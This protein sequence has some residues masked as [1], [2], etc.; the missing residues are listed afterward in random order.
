MAPAASGQRR[1]TLVDRCSGV[2]HQDHPDGSSQFP[3]AYQPEDH[4]RCVYASTAH[5]PSSYDGRGDDGEEEIDA[6]R[7]ERFYTGALSAITK[8]CGNLLLLY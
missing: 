5:Q 6:D 3:P 7:M 2:Q 4:I 8:V 1:S